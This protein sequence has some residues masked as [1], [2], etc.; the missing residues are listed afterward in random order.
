MSIY[1][2]NPQ[3]PGGQRSPVDDLLDS[4]SQNRNQGATGGAGPGGSAP[5]R[6]GMPRP[7]TNVGYSPQPTGQRSGLPQQGVVGTPNLGAASEIMRLINQGVLSPD[8][9]R[10]AGV[11]P[12]ISTMSVGQRG[13]N[14]AGVAQGR[15]DPRTGQWSGGTPA[16]G[17]MGGP[18]GPGGAMPPGG[19]AGYQ[20]EQ[21]PFELSIQNAISGNL[22]DQTAQRRRMQ[23]TLGESISGATSNAMEQTR[24]DAVRRGA[25][26]A[27]GD[28]DIRDQL[29][30]SIM[31]GGADQARGRNEIESILQGFKNQAI[32]QGTS[33]L[34]EQG[35]DVRSLREM[36]TMLE[37]L[38]QQN[39]PL[40]GINFSLGGR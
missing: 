35:Q 1:G 19:G 30:R 13:M 5:G 34:G 38:K 9:A 11:M 25:T 16:P 20:R 15:Y 31:Q 6:G 39:S 40:S 32:G 36:I 3:R 23:T 4:L 22:G 18:G 21:S 2:I 12:D 26:G 29:N 33:L 24:E 28:A 8:Q 37:A 10:Q 14:P 17:G 27:Q 7:T